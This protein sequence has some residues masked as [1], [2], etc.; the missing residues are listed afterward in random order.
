MA[1]RDTDVASV[2]VTS[3]AG[4]VHVQVR[5]THMYL[6]V[7]VCLRLVLHCNV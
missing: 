7:H 6:C 3:L 4:I 5:I 2:D 1:G